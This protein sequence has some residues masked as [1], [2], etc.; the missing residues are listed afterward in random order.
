MNEYI[1]TFGAGQEHENGF[2][3]IKADSS[4]AARD[5]MFEVF[6]SKW[7]MQYDAPNAREK[8]GVDRWGM[9]EVK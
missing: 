4:H 6:G 5:R 7:S 9:H 2:Y 8:A 1:F 3:V